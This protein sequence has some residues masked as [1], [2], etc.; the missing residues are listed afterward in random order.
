MNV[1]KHMD[2]HGG[3][4]PLLRVSATLWLPYPSSVIASVLSPN[5]STAVP[6]RSSI[7]T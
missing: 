3:S 7:A 2:L 5:F 4:Q 1:P 6:M